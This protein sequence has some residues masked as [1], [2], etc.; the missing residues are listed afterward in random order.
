M[1]Q[2]P[3]GEMGHHHP[4]ELLSN[5]FRGLAAQDDLG[6]AQVGLQFVQGGLNLPTLMI[7]SRQFFGRRLPIIENR[8]RQPDMPG[9]RPGITFWAKAI[10][11][12]RQP[13][14]WAPHST[15]VPFSSKPTKRIC[16]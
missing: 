16:G 4:I 1:H 7:E 3:H 13:L 6:A 15:W 14:M 10:S 2:A 12:V 11:S 9:R 8:C 5:Q